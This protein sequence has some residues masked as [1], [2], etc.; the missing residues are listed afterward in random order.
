MLMSKSLQQSSIR[1]Q[2]TY[3]R[4]YV[5]AD[6]YTYVRTY[7]SAH[8]KCNGRTIYKLGSVSHCMLMIGPQL[9]LLQK[10]V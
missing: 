2:H 7:T 5:F 6:T 8:I 10:V 3:I 1:R 9:F 4:T